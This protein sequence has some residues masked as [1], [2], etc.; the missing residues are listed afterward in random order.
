M[1]TAGAFAQPGRALVEAPAASK[2][3]LPSETR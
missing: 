1:L 3:K 2:P